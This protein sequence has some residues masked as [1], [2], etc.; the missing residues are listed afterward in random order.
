MKTQVI[1]ESL[2]LLF[3]TVNELMEHK[4][5]LNYGEMM[6]AILRIVF[7]SNDTASDSRLFQF[8]NDPRDSAAILEV[9]KDLFIHI[10]DEKIEE[11]RKMHD[12]KNVPQVKVSIY[13]FQITVEIRERL[14][15][16]FDRFHKMVPSTDRDS[17]SFIYPYLCLFKDTLDVLIFRH[18]KFFMGVHRNNAE[19]ETILSKSKWLLD[20]ILDQ[21]PTTT[22]FETSLQDKVGTQDGVAHLLTANDK[23][24][25]IC[26]EEI[27]EN[28]DFAVL[29]T[30]NHL[31]C[32]DCAEVTLMGDVSDVATYEEVDGYDVALDK[33]GKC[34]CCRKEVMEWT[35]SKLL[36]FEQENG[37]SQLQYPED[38]SLQYEEYQNVKRFEYFLIESIGNNYSVPFTWM[39][40][41]NFIGTCNDIWLV[42]N[43]DQRQDIM[44]LCLN[45]NNLIQ[46]FDN[47]KI[48]PIM[49]S[50][51][52]SQ[53]HAFVQY[54][55]AH[56]KMKEEDLTLDLLEE[57]NDR[58]VKSGSISTFLYM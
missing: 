15:I 20:S 21:G 55:L 30:C 23:S 40:I 27:N 41:D 58:I 24:C 48:S 17:D 6:L 12:E 26:L 54:M 19:M 5:S 56:E 33:I 28:S 46:L 39:A 35:T 29:D 14:E 31:M 42:E 18:Y 49:F 7:K 4:S 38:K 25:A 10:R 45:M 47:D 32:T 9:V 34:P 36:I 37:C 2:R 44:M 43:E 57:I 11:L 1:N 8:M 13:I 22:H 3:T 16:M 50:L 51:N 52:L 53:L